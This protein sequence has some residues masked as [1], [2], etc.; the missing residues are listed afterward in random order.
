MSFLQ[1]LLRHPNRIVGSWR[2][3]LHSSVSLDTTVTNTVISCYKFHIVSKLLKQKVIIL[4]F[5]Y[6]IFDLF[7]LWLSYMIHIRVIQVFSWK[8]IIDAG[9]MKARSGEWW[10]HWFEQ[11]P[12]CSPYTSFRHD[13]LDTTCLSEQH[14]WSLTSHRLPRCAL[15][16]IL[17]LFQLLLWRTVS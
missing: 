2:C 10:L 9:R 1:A 8:V 6:V 16:I 4:F 14:T 12:Q 5:A 17:I 7:P 3:I 13:V 11:R 15:F